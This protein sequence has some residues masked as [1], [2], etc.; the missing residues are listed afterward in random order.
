[1]EYLGLSESTLEQSGGIHTAKEISQQPEL[2]KK[3]Y[4]SVCF[5]RK[6]I[7]AYL[8][9]IKEHTDKFILTGAGTSAFIGLSLEGAFRRQ[10]SQQVE[11]VPTTDLVSHPGN[12]FYPEQRIVLVSF[13]RS[14]NSPESE[15]AAILAERLSKQ[16]YHLIITCDA[17]GKL[18]S[19][20]SQGKKYVF[21]L[22]PDAN[23]QGLAMTSSYTGMMWSALLFARIHQVEEFSRQLDALVM[24]AESMIHDQYHQIRELAEMDFDRAVFLGSGPLLGTATEAHLKLQ[25]L[26]DGKVICKKDSYLGFRHGPKSVIDKET[27]L[28]CFF[29]N[30]FYVSKYEKDLVGSV[31]DDQLTS[32]IVGV[33]EN[34]HIDLNFTTAM[35]YNGAPDAQLEEELLAM[36]H[37]IPAQMLAFYKS[38]ALG[39]QPDEPSAERGAISRVVQGVHIYLE[40]VTY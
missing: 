5:Q 13:A 23:D 33:F 24:A 7:E 30:D 17:D 8:N 37:I 40:D 21:V 29:S 6:E 3:I 12:Y 25:E 22:P 16:V 35:E 4:D 34:K 9:E 14:G 10:F 26:T 31:A 38:L 36:V 18:A 39:Y 27:L 11:V 19:F 15:A 32:R 28:V 20:K 2:W 1:M